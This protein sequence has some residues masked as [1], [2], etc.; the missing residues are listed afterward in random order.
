MSITEEKDREGDAA[1]T[2]EASGASEAVTAREAAIG[3]DS[4]RAVAAPL[5][6]RIQFLLTRSTAELPDSWS[7]ELISLY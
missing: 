3:E 2:G 1:R 4:A 6:R 7:Y 5:N